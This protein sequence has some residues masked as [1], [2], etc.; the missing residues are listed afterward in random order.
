MKEWPDFFLIGAMKA[1][2]TALHHCLNKHPDIFMSRPKE[3]GFFSRDD[4]FAKG[5]IWY[6]GYFKGAAD[7]QVWG[8][9]STCYSRMPIYPNTAARIYNVNPNA[10]FLY[11]V[12]DP[13]LRA[14]SHYKHRMDETVISG[15]PILTYKEFLKV[16]TEVLNTGKYYYQIKPYYDLFGADNVY[17]CSFCD[18]VD[19]TSKTLFEIC[20]FLNV[21]PS[22]LSETIFPIKNEAGSSLNYFYTNQYIRVLRNSLLVKPII[23]LMPS[24]AKKAG[25]S[26]LKSTLMRSG[27]MRKKVTKDHAVLSVPD[28][29]DKRFLSEYYKNDLTDF[30]AL[31]GL[32]ITCWKSFKEH[33]GLS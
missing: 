5:Y 30:Q 16:D 9:S 3:P 6:R 29:E 2:S 24:S 27:L 23:D 31:T 32:D 20:S 22:S 21:D 4:R 8:D 11:V 1:G 17:V 10:K 7:S 26:V 28:E 12:R 13:V 33:D 25:V 15:R 14:F 19:N 18:L